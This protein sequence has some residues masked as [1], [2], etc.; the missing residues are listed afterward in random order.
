M[1]HIVRTSKGHFQYAGFIFP[2]DHIQFFA[3]ELR[4]SLF[5]ETSNGGYRVQQGRVTNFVKWTDIRVILE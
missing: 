5:D 1:N 4:Q 2:E 3:R